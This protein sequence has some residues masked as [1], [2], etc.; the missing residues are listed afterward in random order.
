MIFREIHGSSCVRQ[1]S[2]FICHK[3][4]HQELPFI[5]HICKDSHIE[6]FTQITVFFQISIHVAAQLHLIIYII[7]I[8]GTYR[9]FRFQSQNLSRLKLAS[10]RICIREQSV[11][12]IIHPDCQRLA[13]QICRR[14][15]QISDYVSICL[16]D[17]IADCQTQHFTFLDRNICRNRILQVIIPFD[18]K[19]LFL[20]CKCYLLDCHFFRHIGC[21]LHHGSQM[22]EIENQASFFRTSTSCT[23]EIITSYSGRTIVSV[24]R[25]TFIIY[26]NC[27]FRTLSGKIFSAERIICIISSTRLQLPAASRK[28][29][30]S[31]T[32]SRLH[33]K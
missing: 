17:H 7:R 3:R 2:V 26:P 8:I 18:H 9:N 1:V 12:I 23:Q 16:T 11:P 31:C 22:S 15:H 24:L 25:L 32:G 13:S 19:F 4:L 27:I 33:G 21:N 30:I 28:D 10:N 14:D 5:V 29:C 6:V 20:G